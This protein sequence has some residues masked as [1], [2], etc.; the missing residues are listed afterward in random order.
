[1]FFRYSPSQTE[2]DD[3]NQDPVTSKPKVLGKEQAKKRLMAFSLSKQTISPVKK[4]NKLNS[5]KNSKEK[6]PNPNK[7]VGVQE[8]FRATVSAIE[9]EKKRML[10]TMPNY[11]IPEKL[12]NFSMTGSSELY[13][14]SLIFVFFLQ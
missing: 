7:G 3:E 4:Q 6:P 9:E 13:F 5:N 14:Y 8:Q 2:S 12:M 11:L 1:M 10:K